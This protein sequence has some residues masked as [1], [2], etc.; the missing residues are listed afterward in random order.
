M[1]VSQHTPVLD[2]VKNVLRR[3]SGHYEFSVDALE[4]ISAISAIKMRALIADQRN[5]MLVTPALVAIASTRFRAAFT[6]L[7]RKGGAV[8]VE[9][10]LNQTGLGIRT[11]IAARIENQGPDVALKAL[12]TGPGTWSEYKARHRLDPRIGWATGAMRKA[13]LRSPFRLRKV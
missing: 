11:A 8:R 4:G 3:L 13:I 6:E 2:A 1:R 10:L 5:F 9:Y 7:L 12:P